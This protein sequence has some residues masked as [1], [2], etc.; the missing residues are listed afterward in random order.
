MLYT[1]EPTT[2][3]CTEVA[4]SECQCTDCN[5]CV[6]DPLCKWDG[7]TCHLSSNYQ[8]QAFTTHCPP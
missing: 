4:N 7:T 2:Q 8:G 6:N 5:R 1:F 3:Q